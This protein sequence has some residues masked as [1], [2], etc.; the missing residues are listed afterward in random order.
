MRGEQAGEEKI[1]TTK[2]RKE[3]R[4]RFNLDKDRE[5]NESKRKGRKRA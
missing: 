1:L 5:A 3:C 2:E 4:S